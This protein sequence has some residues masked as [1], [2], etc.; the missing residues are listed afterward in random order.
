[1]NDGYYQLG[2][3]LPYWFG[4]TAWAFLILI[5]SAIGIWRGYRRWEKLVSELAELPAA[6]VELRKPGTL[7]ERLTE[8]KCHELWK[9]AVASATRIQTSL[10]HGSR[11]EWLQGH[12]AQH[13]AVLAKFREALLQ[14]Q[15]TGELQSVLLDVEGECVC[16]MAFP[17]RYEH[18]QLL[19]R[20]PA[21]AQGWLRHGETLREICT[22]QRSIHCFLFFVS[23]DARTGL[24]AYCLEAGPLRVAAETLL[25][26]TE[27]R[28]TDL[29]VVP[30]TCDF[31]LV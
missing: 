20:Y 1:M 29:S 15:Q 2:A 30:E 21:L 31:S 28:R 9:L 27:R 8:S 4:W 22:D 13:P 16:V 19:R 14:A 12:L 7:D 18:P 23:Q 5:P 26:E 25:D 17:G 6:L 3:R 11:A 24:A 10:G